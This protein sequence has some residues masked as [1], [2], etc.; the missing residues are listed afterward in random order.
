ML[1]LRPKCRPSVDTSP[2]SESRILRSVATHWNK[3]SATGGGVI[4]R[5]GGATSAVAAAD[6]A[7]GGFVAVAPSGSFFRPISRRRQPKAVWAHRA[8]GSGT[9]WRPGGLP[10]PRSCPAWPRLYAAGS[11]HQC[12][13][14]EQKPTGFS[15][16]ARVER[17]RRPACH[18]SAEECHRVAS[19]GG[20]RLLPVVHRGAATRSHPAAQLLWWRSRECPRHRHRTKECV[21]C[22]G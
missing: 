10:P 17:R 13:R 8:A 6:V 14:S 21:S 5:G 1:A 2:R 4:V 9:I 3:R 19:G 11:R 20:V 7:D 15:A 12:P 18:E 22:C 16:I